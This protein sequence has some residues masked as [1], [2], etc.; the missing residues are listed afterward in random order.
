MEPEDKLEEI[1]ELFESELEE[2]K[3]QYN[4]KI[5]EEKEKL[6]EYILSDPAFKHCTN[7]HFRRQYTIDLFKNKLGKEFIELKQ[8]WLNPEVISYVYCGA[9][10]MIEKIWRELKKR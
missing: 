7:K 3:E 10:D 1:L 6:K 4:L 2:E 9:I 8:H 5:E